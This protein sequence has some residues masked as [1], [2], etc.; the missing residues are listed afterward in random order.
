MT[1]GFVCLPSISA[2]QQLKEGFESLFDVRQCSSL[3]REI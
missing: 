3:L 1:P 2:R